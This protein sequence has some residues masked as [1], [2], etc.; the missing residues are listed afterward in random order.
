M[1]PRP[2]DLSAARCCW[3]AAVCAVVIGSACSQTARAAYVV[4]DDFESYVPGT[5]MNGQSDGSGTWIT[6]TT[7]GGENFY[8]AADSTRPGNHVL[9]V[10]NHLT[11]GAAN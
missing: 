3:R 7:A 2:I 1:N 6:T 11:D 4:I 5:S 9:N 10:T 8:S